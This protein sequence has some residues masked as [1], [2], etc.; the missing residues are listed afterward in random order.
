MT[1][2]IYQV[3]AFTDKLFS[4]NPAAICP[5]DKWLSDEVMQHIAAEN[6]LSETAYL[7]NEGK[8]IH[9]RWFTPTHE[10]DLCGH[11]TLAAAHVVKTILG[12]EAALIP[13]FSPRSGAL[14]VS[15]NDSGYTLDFPSDS[16]SSAEYLPEFKRV[17]GKVPQEVLKGTSDYLLVFESE[18]D[19]RNLSPDFNELA[20]INTRGFIATAPGTSV[21][22]V[23]RFFAPRYGINEDPVTGSAHTT[24][25]PFW[26]T[27]LKKTKLEALQL[28]KRGGRLTCEVKGDRIL[29]SGNAVLFL[30]GEIF[31]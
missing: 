24:L 12:F 20:K 3:D 13:F 31:V 25:T 26:A 9:I 11:A 30:K 4:G 16:I 8:Q 18:E 19:I 28:S 27:R 5:L 23:S 1:I 14:P 2:P 29:I 17:F 15:I 21:D 22:F 10:V 7:V 6:N